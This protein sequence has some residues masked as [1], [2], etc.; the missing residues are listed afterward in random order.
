MIL[1]FAFALLVQTGL[2]QL[3]HVYVLAGLLGIVSS[4]DL[5]TQQ[6]FIGDLSG[7]DQVRRAVV[8]NSMIIQISRTA[9]PALAGWLIGALGVAPAFWINGATFPAVIAT[10][11]LI[12]AT[13]VRLGARGNA[14]GDYRQALRFIRKNPRVLDLVL[15]TALVAFLAMS[16]LFIF[17]AVA[18]RAYGA[19]P[20]LYGVM[21]GASGAGALVG[22][23]V[24]TPIAQGFRRTGLVLTAATLWSGAWLMVFALTTRVPLALA[25]I[26]FTSL[27]VPVVLTTANGLIQVLAPPD[28]RA[29]L[30]T[31][32]LMVSF[33]VLPLA[34]VL[35]GLNSD[36]I[37]PLPALG[38]NGGLLTAASLLMLV[39]RRG[40]GSW[41]VDGGAGLHSNV[42]GAGPSG[43]GAR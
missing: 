13:Q 12:R 40:L 33:G 37:G 9:G 6:A 23:E 3:W 28:M 26:F 27:T 17:P 8:T 7:M 35:T 24:L 29:R 1:A 20:E 18:G 31:T 19:G 14:L 36:F 34:T 16:A 22:S 4:L 25:A 32:L 5:P 15:F 21:L 43:A 2:I 30:L 10:L 41:E 38:I 42:V 39:L 11:V